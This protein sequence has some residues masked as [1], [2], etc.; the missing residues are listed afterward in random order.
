VYSI[1]EMTLRTDPLSGSSKKH[2]ST[3]ESGS[4]I[5]IGIVSASAVRPSASSTTTLNVRVA[6]VLR[7]EHVVDVREV[8]QGQVALELLVVQVEA[9]LDHAWSS[10]AASVSVERPRLVEEVRAGVER[11]DLGRLVLLRASRRPGARRPGG[12]R[13]RRSGLLA[14]GPRD[15]LHPGSGGSGSVVVGVG[16]SVVPPE[17][18]AFGGNSA[19]LSA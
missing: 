3:P 14:A 4:E 12:R 16:G 15:G 18:S 8:R 19:M 10:L 5:V 2:R 6:V 9:D 13:P 11:V 1:A 7:R 17:V